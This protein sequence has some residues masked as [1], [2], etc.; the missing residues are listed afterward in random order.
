[1]SS[2]I[3][4][5]LKNPTQNFSFIINNSIVSLT[6]HLQP[7]HYFWRSPSTSET[8]LTSVYFSFSVAETL[9]LTFIGFDDPKLVLNSFHGINK[10]CAFRLLIGDI[11]FL[12]LNSREKPAEHIK[13][14]LSI[15]TCSTASNK[16]TWDAACKQNHKKRQTA[17][18]VKLNNDTNFNMLWVWVK[19]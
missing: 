16:V 7:R 4:H 6:W 3:H 8:D 10:A 19:R 11:I 14:L 1:M 9:I 5:S 18:S 13:F 12:G 2:I 17:T 15:R